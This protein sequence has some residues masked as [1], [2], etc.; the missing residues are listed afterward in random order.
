MAAEGGATAFYMERP[1][2]GSAVN[3]LR[4]RRRNSAGRRRS[5]GAAADGAI[6]SAAMGMEGGA[7]L[8]SQVVANARR[9]LASAYLPPSG[10]ATAWKS[11]F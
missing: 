4:S 5:G 2:S 1:A 7:T 6:P 9:E 8:G 3:M 11:V 10:M